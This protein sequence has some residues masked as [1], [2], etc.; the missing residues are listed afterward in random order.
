MINFYNEFLTCGLKANISDVVDHINYVKDKIGADHVG[1]GSD[2]DGVPLTPDGLEDVSK[3]P[4]LFAAL[5]Q[6]GW[7]EE[8]LGK[9]AGDNL[10]RV[11]RD[12]E[13][14]N[15]FQLVLIKWSLKR[16]F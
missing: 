9:L 14:V 3:Y 8:E 10:I 2:F 4:D 16:V 7:S 1:I 15:Y 6:T 5:L 11:L 13:K 12:V